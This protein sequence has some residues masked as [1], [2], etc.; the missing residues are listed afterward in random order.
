MRVE[1]ISDTL[2]APTWLQG[3]RHC[4]RVEAESHSVLIVSLRGHNGTAIMGIKGRADLILFAQVLIW[5]PVTVNNLICPGA[6]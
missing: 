1:R 3:D 5:Q 6:L 4:V 2:Q